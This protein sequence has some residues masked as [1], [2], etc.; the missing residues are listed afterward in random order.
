MKNRFYNEYRR[1][2]K[3]LADNNSEKICRI[4]DTMFRKFG[5]NVASTIEYAIEKR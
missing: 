2:R 5:V 3:A 1:L 4:I